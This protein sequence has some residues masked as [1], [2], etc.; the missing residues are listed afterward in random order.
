MN[1]RRNNEIK[2]VVTAFTI[3]AALIS[4]LLTARD[5]NAAP[6]TTK[7]STVTVKRAKKSKPVYVKMTG[8]RRAAENRAQQLYTSALAQ[9][10]ADEQAV[11]DARAAAA[12]ANAPAT[13]SNGTNGVGANA[14]PGVFSVPGSPN[15]L[16]IGGGYS[17]FAYGGSTYIV[18]QSYGNGY[19]GGFGNGGIIVATP[20][21]INF[22]GAFSIGSGN[23]GNGILFGGPFPY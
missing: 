20:G 5:A 23:N 13:A 21:G 1:T 19:G 6:P 10:A 3:T 14:Q 12:E 8:D 16:V 11:A 7:K 4:G 2:A 17:P 9:K 22:P 15:T 18:P